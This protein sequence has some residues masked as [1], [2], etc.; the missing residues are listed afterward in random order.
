MRYIV[1]PAKKMS[2]VDGVFAWRDEPQFIE[3][4]E[5]LMT[6]IRSLDYDQV[7]EL[8]K[9]SDMLCS[10]NF[11]R[12][13]TMSLRDN[14]A[15]LSPAIFA[16]EG[17][18]YQNMAPHVME[19]AHLEYL[20]EHVRIL[21]GFY[22]I[23]RPF[24]CVVPYRLEMQAKL[25]VAGACDLYEFWGKRLAYA[26]AKETDTVVNLASV[27]YAKAIT[28][29]AAEAGIR[30]ITCLFG[31]ERAGKLVQRSTAAKAARGSI[32]RWCAERG[33]EAIADLQAFDVGG[34]CYQATMSDQ[35]TMVFTVK[36]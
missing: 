25:A 31:F 30:I 14:P 32:V 9:A 5:Q 28:P 16:Y 27:E 26:L 4:S 29:Y 17:I 10:L 1:S 8:W 24:D 19:E 35:D 22:G 20:Q 2:I 23:L 3:H 33:V 34:Y 11:E 18:Q 13:R 7:K 15:L 12:F 21:S 6:E 36:E